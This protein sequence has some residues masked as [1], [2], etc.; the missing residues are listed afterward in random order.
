MGVGVQ[1]YSG[2]QEGVDGRMWLNHGVY[3]SVSS[4]GLTSI[5]RDTM[6]VGPS[7]PIPGAAGWLNGISIDPDG[8]VWT[9]SP[10]AN[11]VFRY[12]PM[13][14]VI[15][16]Y[17]GLNNPYTYSDMTGSGLLNTACGSPTG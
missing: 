11:S 12:N 4:M 14:G 17:A 5:D 2:I 16:S 13:S 10:S 6:V 15:D 9:V 1:G 3:D 8:N 7:I